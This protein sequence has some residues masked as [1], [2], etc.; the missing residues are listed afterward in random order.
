MTDAPRDPPT[1][2][3]QGP[4]TMHQHRSIWAPPSAN[5]DSRQSPDRDRLLKSGRLEIPRNCQ[6]L[7]FV[8]LPFRTATPGE[9][10]AVQA[11]R[12]STRIIAKFSNLE[13]EQG[14]YLI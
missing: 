4:D 14:I 3:R 12:N 7:A 10:G 11:C 5:L 8:N 6:K 13:L 9:T 1:K 2:P